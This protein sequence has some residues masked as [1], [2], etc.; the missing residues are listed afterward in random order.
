MFA[1][2]WMSTWGTCWAPQAREPQ[3][4]PFPRRPNLPTLPPI[5]S[6]CEAGQARPG[7]ET[8]IGSG[9][10]WS[11]QGR[12]LG[13]SERVLQCVL[14]HGPSQYVEGAGSAVYPA[15]PGPLEEQTSALAL[16]MSQSHTGTHS[17]QGTITISCHP[18]WPCQPEA[19]NRPPSCCY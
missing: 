10:R 17:G 19:T 16:G 15:S 12:A 4:G 6:Q 14:H 9:V 8:S 3:K 18:S 5:P 7:R 2:V 1:S 13:S 11:H